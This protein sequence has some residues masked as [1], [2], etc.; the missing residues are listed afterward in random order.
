M[1]IRTSSLTFI[2]FVYVIIYKYVKVYTECTVLKSLF[3][4]KSIVL[5][6]EFMLTA[7]ISTCIASISPECICL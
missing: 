5:F 6:L 3:I 1:M 4:S 2:W 7:C